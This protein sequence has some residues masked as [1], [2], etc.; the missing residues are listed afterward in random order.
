LAAAARYATIFLLTFSVRITLPSLF[1]LRATQI[2]PHLHHAYVVVDV[3]THLPP[4][5]CQPPLPFGY[6]LGLPQRRIAVAATNQAAAVHWVRGEK[7]MFGHTWFSFLP[8][9]LVTE[10]PVQRDAA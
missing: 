1:P 7:E 10:L 5:L 6:L 8:C 2:A 9:D 4:N 3:S